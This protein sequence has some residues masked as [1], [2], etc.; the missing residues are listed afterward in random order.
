VGS[1]ADVSVFDLET[2]V[3]AFKDAWRKKRLGTKRLECVLTVRDGKIVYDLNGLA[4]P[5][6]NTAGDY[7]VI[8]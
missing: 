4:F 5:L 7:G 3:F 1:I 8:E 2:G 6:W